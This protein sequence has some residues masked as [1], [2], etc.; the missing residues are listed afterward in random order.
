LGHAGFKLTDSQTPINSIKSGN[1]VETLKLA[2]W[3]YENGIL[4]TPFI[5]PS[6]PENEGRIR[7]IAG[8]NLEAS[9]IE[10]VVNCVNQHKKIRA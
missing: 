1:S 3:F 4:T 6:V 5:Y 7:I 8:A 10:Y 9:S 2:R